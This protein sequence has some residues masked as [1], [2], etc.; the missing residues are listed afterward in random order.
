MMS[1][2]LCRRQFLKAGVGLIA[3]GASALMF[4]DRAVVLAQPA[5]QTS[6]TKN[7]LYTKGCYLLVQ[8]LRSTDSPCLFAAKLG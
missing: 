6:Q 8:G 7:T 1:D 2:E 4:G 3:G 5:R